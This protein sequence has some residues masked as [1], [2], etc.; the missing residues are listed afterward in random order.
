[1]TNEAG[2]NIGGPK[3]EIALEQGGGKPAILNCPAC[4]AENIQGTD[5]CV[6][7]NSDLR[8]LD[9]PPQTWAPGEGPPGERVDRLARHEPLT[10]APRTPLRDVIAAMRDAGRGC[11]L[12]VEGERVVG[13]FTERDLLHRVTPRPDG[14]LDTPVSEYMTPDPS[15]MRPDESVLVALNEMGVGGFRHIPLVDEGGR[16]RGILSGRDVLEYIEQRARPS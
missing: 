15:T 11:V 13:V 14:A 4:G 10:V 7:C 6:N 9:I 2:Y 5:Y 8:T 1:M 12:V 16:L 3:R